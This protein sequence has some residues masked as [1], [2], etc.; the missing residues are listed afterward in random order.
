MTEDYELGLI[1]SKTGRGSAFLRLRDGDGNLVA[2]TSYFPGSLAT[3]VRQKTRWIHGIAFQGWDRLGWSARPLEF[4]MALRD[5][6]GPLT[7][8]VLAAAYALL[9]LDGV[10]GLAQIAGLVP[11]LPLTEAQ[12][13]FLK[14]GLLG[15]A[16]RAGMKFLLVGHEYG[17]PEGL[18]ATLRIPVANVIAIMAG[19]RAIASYVRSLAGEPVRWDKTEHLAHPAAK[20]AAGA[21]A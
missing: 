20:R 11:Y 10:L 21:S 8:L 15:L 13:A 14:I 9:A 5:R 12:H 18:R 3:A 19:R 16:W 6:R 4:W 7:A 2:T 1:L 17:W